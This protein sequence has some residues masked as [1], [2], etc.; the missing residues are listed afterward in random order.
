MPEKVSCEQCQIWMEPEECWQVKAYSDKPV[1]LC[2]SICLQEFAE[3]Q[4]V[5]DF[6]DDDEEG[7]GFQV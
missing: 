4:V 7:Y 3:V 6:L 1:Y 2:S 5:A